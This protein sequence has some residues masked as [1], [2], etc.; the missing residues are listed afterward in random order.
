MEGW[1]AKQ[2]TDK[3]KET[4]PTN[5]MEGS[6]ENEYEMSISEGVQKRKGDSG[7]TELKQRKTKRIK[8]EN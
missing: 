3:E 6:L 1:K 5:P 2:D 7:D 4:E 8:L